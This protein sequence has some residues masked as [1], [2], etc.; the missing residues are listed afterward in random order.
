M[1]RELRDFFAECA[2]PSR[3][4]GNLFG[5]LNRKCKVRGGDFNQLGDFHPQ[6]CDLRIPIRYQRCKIV[7]DD[8]YDYWQWDGNW[9]Q[10]CITHDKKIPAS[11]YISMCG[12]YRNP[13]PLDLLAEAGR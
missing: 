5:L 8:N 12:A 4:L 11:L 3:S 2:P 7:V 6:D 9:T 1:D 13:S 10:K